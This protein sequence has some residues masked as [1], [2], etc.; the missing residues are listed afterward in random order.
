VPVPQEPKTVMVAQGPILD[1]DTVVT[2][3]S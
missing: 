3:A 1:V 2:P